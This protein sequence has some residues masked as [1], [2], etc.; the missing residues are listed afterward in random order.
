[1]SLDRL[2]S[3]PIMKVRLGRRFIA[4]PPRETYIAMRDLKAFWRGVRALTRREGREAITVLLMTGMRLN[5]G[6]GIEWRHVDLRNGYLLVPHGTEG[7]K[8]FTGAFPLSDSVV[9]LLA[10][11]YVRRELGAVHAFPSRSTSETPEHLTRIGGALSRACALAGIPRVTAHDLRRTYATVCGLAFDGDLAKVGALLGHNWAVTKGAITARYIQ[12]ELATL[13][14]M[15]NEVAA[16]ILELIGERAV[17]DETAAK[18]RRA[19]LT[20]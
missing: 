11:R 3:N 15:A 20:I 1:M 19:G 18:L 5:A 16:L 8:G 4:A 10:A 6:L 17:S 7:W 12:T 13:R 14:A 2:D 9:S